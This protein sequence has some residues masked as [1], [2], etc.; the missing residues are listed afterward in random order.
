[1]RITAAAVRQMATQFGSGLDDPIYNRYT[2]HRRFKALFGASVVHVRDMFNL[3]NDEIE[4]QNCA[5]AIWMMTALHWMRA[6]PTIDA[7]A[8]QL[9]HD[10]KTVRKWIWRHVDLMAR[11]ELVCTSYE[12][13]YECI[14]SHPT[15]PKQRRIRHHINHFRA[16]VDELE[17]ILYDENAQTLD[18][19]PVVA[20][21]E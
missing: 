13:T 1:M 3:I 11:L 6:Y 5:N 9:G 17:R 8:T 7:L 18:G 16:R 12:I 19:L 21:D 14:P 2:W 10:E 20:R 4:E 15:K